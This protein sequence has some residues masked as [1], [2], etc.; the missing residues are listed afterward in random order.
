MCMVRHIVTSFDLSKVCKERKY[1]EAG[2]VLIPIIHVIQRRQHIKTE[3]D[4]LQAG[5]ISGSIS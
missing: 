4:I 2:E 1:S 3:S 5:E